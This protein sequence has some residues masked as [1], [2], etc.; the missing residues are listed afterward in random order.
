M[1]T[2]ER[3]IEA[4]NAAQSSGQAFSFFESALA[5]MGY[6]RICYSL[7]TDHP[8]SGMPAGHGIMRNYPEDWMK[9]YLANDYVEKDPVPRHC[10]SAIFPF[11]WGELVGSGRLSPDQHRVMNEANE[12]RLLDGIAVPL[13]GM[14]GELAGV[15]IASSA[16]GVQ[17]DKTMLRKIG[18]MASQFHLV[19]TEK[20]FRRNSAKM[21]HLTGREREILVWAAEGKS[22]GVV[23]EIL[24]I[25]HSAVRFHMNNIFRKLDANERTLAVV[26]AIRHGLIQPQKIRL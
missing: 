5:E 10:F 22:D 6:D 1:F 11:T 25:T 13:H 4:T 8:S 2:V 12:A 16:G 15:G 9:H 23:A 14:N 20:E 18:A 21:P 17:P 7:I 24:G 3:F 19:Y 26:K